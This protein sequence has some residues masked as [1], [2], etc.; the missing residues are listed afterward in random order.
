MTKF[1][2]GE[3]GNPSGRP[4]GSKNKNTEEIR[5]KLNGFI[6][7]KI[8]DLD[9][10]WSGL[11]KKQRSDFL[12]KILEFCVP[13]LRSTD[14]TFE[15]PKPPENIDLSVLS[16]QELKFLLKI[17][18]KLGTYKPEINILPELLN[19]PD[20]NVSEAE[21][22]PDSDQAEIMPENPLSDS[23]ENEINIADELNKHNPIEDE[24]FPDWFDPNKHYDWKD[25]RPVGP[26]KI[27]RKHP[28][29]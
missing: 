16:D 22:I 5:D 9:L 26:E 27:K 13:K 11:D 25:G 17:S 24:D 15:I 21:T 3:S 6:S 10:I 29:N 28:F 1:K 2:K 14:L 18:K 12:T 19:K 7:S 23:N 4:A 8:E 20:F